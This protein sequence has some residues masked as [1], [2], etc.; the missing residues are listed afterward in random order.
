MAAGVGS[1]RMDGG[2]AA[3]QCHQSLFALDKRLKSGGT[4]QTG[5]LTQPHNAIHLQ[6]M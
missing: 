4:A 1:A 2:A 5:F 3:E 6:D